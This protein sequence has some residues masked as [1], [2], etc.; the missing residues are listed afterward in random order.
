MRLDEIAARHG[1]TRQA[2]WES[3]HLHPNYP[4]ALELSHAARLDRSEKAIEGAQDG[5]DLA[6]ARTTWQAVSWRAERECPR[7]WGQ[8]SDIGQVGAPTLAVQVVVV[9]DRGAETFGMTQRTNGQIAEIISG[10][11]GV[12][13]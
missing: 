13:R 7:R 10:E 4:A 5:L 2:I 3:V 1:R 8:R 12:P 9:R 6:R 11:S